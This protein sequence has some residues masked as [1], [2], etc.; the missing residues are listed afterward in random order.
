MSIEIKKVYSD[1]PYVDEMVYY[2]MQLGL[3][4]TLKLQQQADA[5]ETLEIIEAADIYIACIEGNV[6]ISQFK[7]F[8]YEALTS[9]KMAEGR[10][11]KDA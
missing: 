4:T 1:N 6:V 10:P 3:N 8:P 2:T 9:A 5:A 11:R 7:E